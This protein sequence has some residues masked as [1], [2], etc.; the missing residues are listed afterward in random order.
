MVFIWVNIFIFIE[1][2]LYTNLRYTNKTCE[3]KEALDDSSTGDYVF[4]REYNTTDIFKYIM[5]K[6][7]GCILCKTYF[8]H[9][10]TIVKIN[11]VPYIL[12]L[13]PEPLYCQY[14]KTTEFGL[15]LVDAYER[16]KDFH[17]RVI[18]S[19]NNLH[20]YIQEPD[21][22]EFMD[23]YHTLQF[24][25]DNIMCTNAITKYLSC[26]RVFNENHNYIYPYDFIFPCDFNDPHIYTVDFTNTENVIIKNKFYYQHENI[27]NNSSD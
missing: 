5:C 23:K 19:K 26:V 15:K 20:E 27:N 24:M 14:K 4:F 10:G 13:N 9:I 22:F 12:E 25:K 8:A 11:N 7:S 2:K 6:I 3:L 17:G 21:I 18:L 1:Y 16:I